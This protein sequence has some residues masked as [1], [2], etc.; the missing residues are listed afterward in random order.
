MAISPDTPAK[1]REMAESYGIEFALLEDKDL[2]LAKQ[3]AGVSSDGF[4]LPST[5]ILRADGSVYLRKVGDAKDDRIYAPELLEHLDAMLGVGSKPMPEARGFSRPTRISATL[6]LGAHALDGDWGFAADLSVRALHALGSYLAL[7][8][9][10][11]GLGL[12][13]R[14]VRAA[15][16]AQ[17]QLPLYSGVGELYM[18]VPLGW[19]KRFS[20]DEFDDSG[21]YAGL[22]FGMSFDVNPNVQLHAELAAEGTATSGPRAA[23]ASRGL[24]RTGAAWRF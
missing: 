18:Q 15:L 13:E 12:P 16:L 14:E 11:G 9:E 5:F 21:V 20:D 1:A 7:G 19:A 24:L 4:P 2:E 6:G 22:R 8:V 3:W 17:A 23:L 10:A